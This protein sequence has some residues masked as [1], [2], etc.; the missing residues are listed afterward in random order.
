M[1]HRKKLLFPMIG[2]M[3]ILLFLIAFMLIHFIG[4]RGLA[5]LD[6]TTSNEDISRTHPFKL[7]PKI[8]GNGLSD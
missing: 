3:V 5:S 8:K 1:M 7:N 2:T 6:V 4:T